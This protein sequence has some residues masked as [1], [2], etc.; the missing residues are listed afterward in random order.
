M[1]MELE[2]DFKKRAEVY[3]NSQTPCHIVTKNDSWVNGFIV[4]EPNDYFFIVLDRVSGVEKIHYIDIMVFEEFVGDI[5]RL[6]KKEGD[7]DP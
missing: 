5:D 4:E 6:N 1:E 3:F 2:N 7:D